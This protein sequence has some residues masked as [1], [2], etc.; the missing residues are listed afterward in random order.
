MWDIELL[1]D[2]VY[3]DL[4]AIELVERFLLGRRGSRRVARDRNLPGVGYLVSV[5]SQRSLR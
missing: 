3:D 1:K 2:G 4:P 5:R